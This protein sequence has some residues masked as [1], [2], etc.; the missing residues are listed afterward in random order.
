MSTPD[1][2]IDFGKTA[3]DYARHRAGFPVELFPRLASYGIGL[4]GQR[5]LD[6]GTG[7][8]S[9]ARGFARAGA[10]VTGLDL[11]EPLLGEARQLDQAAGVSIAYAVA[12]AEETGLPASSFD[13]VSAGQCWHWFDRPRAAEEAHRLLVPGGSVAIVHFDW[14][15]L[16]G[17]VVEMTEKLIQAHNPRWKMGGGTGL[18][19]AWLADLSVAG[20]ESLET[21][22]FDIFVSY[23]HEDWRGR[24]RASAGIGATLGPK[25][26]EEFDQQLEM[27][28]AKDFPQDPIQILHRASAVI[29]RKAK[30]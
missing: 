18:Y 25:R 10:T 28:L 27:R 23:S 1:N 15:P 26:V 12:P 29:G 14:I 16:P 13:V 30:A 7:T 11:A 9:L 24:V 4:P 21:F 22:S 17:N 2:S 5:I 3:Q 8:G 19:P 6:L 20:F